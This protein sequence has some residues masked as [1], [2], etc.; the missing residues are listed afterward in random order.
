MWQTYNI[1]IY[2]SLILFTLIIPPIVLKF[3][4]KKMSIKNVAVAKKK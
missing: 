4:D 3:I 2:I 1:I